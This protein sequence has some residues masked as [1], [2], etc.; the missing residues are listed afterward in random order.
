[1]NFTWRSLLASLAFT[2]TVILV[3]VVLPASL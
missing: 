2:A 3:V 1:M